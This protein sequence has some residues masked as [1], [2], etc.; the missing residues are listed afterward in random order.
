MGRWPR[1]KRLSGTNDLEQTRFRFTGDA[2]ITGD[3]SAGY[4]LEIGVDGVN[5]NK[6]NQAR[7]ARRP[8]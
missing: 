8:D 6:F 2:K 4:I 1:V 7:K 5:S 3:W